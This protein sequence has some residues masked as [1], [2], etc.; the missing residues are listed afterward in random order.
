MCGLSCHIEISLY[1]AEMSQ[2]ARASARSPANTERERG[3]M[4]PV[5]E[6][7]MMM[8]CL[9]PNAHGLPPPWDLAN[10]IIFSSRLIVGR[11]L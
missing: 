5:K 2:R 8:W 10:M 9:L 11:E 6:H 1:P 4:S 3:G 7:M